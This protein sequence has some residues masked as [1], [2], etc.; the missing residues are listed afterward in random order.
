M[1]ET[2]NAMAKVR[3]W[4]LLTQNHVLILS[5]ITFAV[6]RAELMRVMFYHPPTLKRVTII[7][8]FPDIT[9]KIC[10][11]QDHSAC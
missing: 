9:N 1:N 6:I 3:Y 2:S 5:L 8:I 7:Y 11:N 10:L 4:F